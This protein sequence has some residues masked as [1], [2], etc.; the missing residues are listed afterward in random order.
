M[1]RTLPDQ[2]TISEVI[3]E[4][5]TRLAAGFHP[6]RA[7]RDAELL[8]LHIVQQANPEHNRATL[9]ANGNK[10]LFP[11]AQSR[12]SELIARRLTGEPIQYILGGCEFYG[13]P[14]KVTRDVLIPRPETE[15]LVENV[16]EV[17]K[18]FV[19]PRIVDVGTGSGAIAV[20]LA[21]HLHDATVTAID[22]SRGALAVARENAERNRVADHIRFLEGDLLAP[23]AGERFEIVVSNPPYVAI[24][25]RASIAVEVREYEPALAL[26]AGEDGLDAYRRLIPAG[27][28]ALVPGGYIA[29]EI[30][31]SQANEIERL[32]ASSGFGE[33]EF[34][35]DLQ[36]IPR[37][38]S[39][40]RP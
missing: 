18:R 36:G 4:A 25:D 32:V 27:H 39:A 37:V 33:I 29:L 13:L 2:P 40:R 1:R 14:F 30:G 3:L 7:R 38:V 21:H 19:R 23:V 35:P 11:R 22:L 10:A 5:E 9:F 28:A 26:F 17:A 12:F 6:E 16:I 34:M 20:A 31:F 15:H 24:I 8:L